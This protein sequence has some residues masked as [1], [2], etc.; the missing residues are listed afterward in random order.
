MYVTFQVQETLSY[1]V[2]LEE[3]VF[4]TKM[5]VKLL[6]KYYPYNKTSGIF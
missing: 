6:Y 5:Y 2:D 3:K 1:L 4:D